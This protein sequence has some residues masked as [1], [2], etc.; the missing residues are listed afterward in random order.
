MARS[1][2]KGPVFQKKLA[3]FGNTTKLNRLF[4]KAI[5]IV[6]FFLSRNISVY[7]GKNFVRLQ[8]TN[9][10]IGHCFGEFVSTR[11]QKKQ[12]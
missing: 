12:L 5:K 1:K 2:W 9:L 6:P 7:N 3:W 10:M 8:I 11:K 4:Y